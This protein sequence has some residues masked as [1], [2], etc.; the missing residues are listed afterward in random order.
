MAKSG[1]KFKYGVDEP[2]RL[3]KKKDAEL[4]YLLVRKAKNGKKSFLADEYDDKFI[5][6]YEVDIEFYEHSVEKLLE[7]F[8]KTSKKDSW[9]TNEVEIKFLE[10]EAK[11]SFYKDILDDEK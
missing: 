8:K 1:P 11:K 3:S 10:L 7:F 5:W 9:N 4:G 6:D 2:G